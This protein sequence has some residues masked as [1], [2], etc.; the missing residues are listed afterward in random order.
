VLELVLLFWVFVV[1]V[2]AALV[3]ALDVCAVAGASTA[4]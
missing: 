4:E 1:V 3:V 2:E